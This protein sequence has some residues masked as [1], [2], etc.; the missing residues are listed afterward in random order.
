MS[1]VEMAKNGLFGVHVL[2]NKII[3]VIIIVAIPL[4]GPVF[5][6]L[7]THLWLE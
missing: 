2:I 7:F 6:V 4:V 1:V 5:A 3:N